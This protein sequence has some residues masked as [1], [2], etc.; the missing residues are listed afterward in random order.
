MSKMNLKTKIV[1]VKLGGN[2]VC[3]QFYLTLLLPDTRIC[4]NFSTV[5]NETL[6]AKGLNYVF[7]IL[8]Y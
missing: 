3:F 7:V 2:S 8:L 1:L 4:V 5:Y 6:V